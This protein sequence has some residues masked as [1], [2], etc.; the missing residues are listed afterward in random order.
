MPVRT[1]APDGCSRTENSAD[2]RI[3]VI[4]GDVA[5]HLVDLKTALEF[6][7]IPAID[8]VVLD[9]SRE[10][11]TEPPWNAWMRWTP[12]VFCMWRATRHPWAVTPVFCVSWVGTWCSFGRSI[13]TR[14]RITWSLWRCLSV[15]RRSLVRAAAAPSSAQLVAVTKKQIIAVLGGWAVHQPAH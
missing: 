13:C 8:A 10:A 2:T 14:I 12:S 15:P 7:E 6:G 11:R 5:R 9:P 4:R 1:S 3:E